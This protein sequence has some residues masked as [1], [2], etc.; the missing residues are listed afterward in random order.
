MSLRAP[1]FIGWRKR[2]VLAV[3]V[4]WITLIGLGIPH[5][6]TAQ[7]TPSSPEA[8]VPPPAAGHFYHGVFPGSAAGDPGEEDSLTLNDLRSYEVHA[9]KTAAWVYFSHNWFSG[10]SFPWDTASWI[11]DAG[12]VPFIRLMLRSSEKQDVEETTF[13]LNRIIEGEFDDDLHAWFSTASDFGSPLIVEYGTEVNGVWFSWNSVWNGAD[14]TDEA[15][16]SLLEKYAGV[17]ERVSL[18]L[19]QI[20]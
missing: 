7:G 4:L 15:L 16:R 17:E 5:A 2:L 14:E 12:S 3:A 19:S 1:S 13:T 10:R 6:V 20:K 11:R 8:S 9:G 18:Y